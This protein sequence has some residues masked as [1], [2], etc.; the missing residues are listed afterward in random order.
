MPTTTP[1]TLTT[2]R[3]HDEEVLQLPAL[4]PL[5]TVVADS[6]TPA[7]TAAKLYTEGVR[8][9]ALDRPAD[10]TGAT[11]ARTIVS[12]MLLLGELT[13]WG[14]VVDWDV[15]L[16]ADPDIWRSFNHLHPPRR[17]LDTEHAK[18]AADIRQEWRSTFYVGKCVYRRGPGFV[19]VRDRRAGGSL[20]RYTLDDPGY[21][22]AVDKLAHGCPA[23]AVAPDVLDHLVGE[24]LAGRAGRL[25]WWLPYRVRRWPWPS[26]AV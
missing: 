20:A 3:D 1:L 19:Q 18:E 12:T 4:R 2:W 25:A 21:L 26:F 22:E 13:S 14:I 6:A 11:G 9:V 23:E 15:A 8:R 10:L 5:T 24:S 7:E 17:I 16:G